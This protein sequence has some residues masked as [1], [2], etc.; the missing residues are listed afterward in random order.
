M[1]SDKDENLLTGAEK[2]RRRA[3][4]R[5]GENRDTAHLIGTEEDPRLLHELQVHQ[6]E[7]EMQNAELRQA[8]D[9]VEATLERYTDLYDFAPVGY[10]T[11]DREGTIRAANLTGAGL[12]GVERARL[13]G[14]RFD[15]LVAA[16]DRPT[17]AT[18]LGKVF[19]CQ[20]KESCEV[21]LLKAENHA[22]FVQIEAMAG[23]SGEEC[24]IALID[25]SERRQL[26]EKLEILHTDLAARSAELE[27]AN[28][29]LEA[30]NYTV[31]HDLRKPLTVI[32]SYCQ[33]VQELC[34]TT[35]DE[36]CRGY[37]R[38]MYEGT[39]RMNRLIDT[40][41]EF[42]RVT[43]V[44][45]RHDKVD[46]STIAQEVALGLQAA[47]PERR[48]TFRIAERISADGDAGLLRV[49]LDN[50]IGNAWKYAGTREETVIEFGVAEVD[51][52]PA[53]FVRD[54][55]SGFDMAHADRLFIPFQRLPGTE[56]EGHGIGLATVERIV[57][58]HGGRVWA[59]GE[60]GMGATF[61]FTLG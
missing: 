31:S 17:F 21:A 26:A 27:S 10:F 55:G 25:I 51:G 24:R 15:L 46:L 47:E 43:R 44:D 40:L 61:Y 32:N 60:P 18:F 36:Q 58:R 6:I 48:V 52:K 1:G 34:G 59:E 42:S 9:E 38:E 50:L 13:I 49:L 14:R 54:N 33:I 20:G 28:I 57:K 53:F 16:A 22:F 12:L 5:L 11:L 39:L 7:L 2:M 30:F 19:T 35:L 37:M 3:E 8:R 45:M 41:L 4:E 56:A 23:T 29:D